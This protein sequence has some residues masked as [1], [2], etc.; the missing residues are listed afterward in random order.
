[1][2]CTLAGTSSVATLFEI[3]FGGVANIF[4]TV[5]GRMQLYSGEYDR[6]RRI[7]GRQ[8]EI[9]IPEIRRAEIGNPEIRKSVGR[10]RNSENP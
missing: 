2:I 8:A 1:M 4:G 10:N 5:F 6:I 3:V 7:G 9:V